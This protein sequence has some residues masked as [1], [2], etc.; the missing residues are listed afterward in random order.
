MVSGGHPFTLA[1]RL[2]PLQAELWA[3]AM[4]MGIPMAMRMRR[5]VVTFVGLCG[6]G[7][8]ARAI[9]LGSRRGV[10]RIRCGGCAA[11]A[12]AIWLRRFAQ[13]LPANRAAR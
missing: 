6:F 9:R 11:P 8:F 4:A 2:G 5:C 3:M 7:S 12:V 10:S 1:A 13:F